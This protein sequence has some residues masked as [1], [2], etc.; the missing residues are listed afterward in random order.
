MG[1]DLETN[2]VKI[3]IPHT[4]YRI[5]SAESALGNMLFP[6][7]PRFREHC[8]ATNLDEIK[9][10]SDLP[11]GVRSSLDFLSSFVP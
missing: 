7:G 10:L 4:L 1:V 11:A 2:T 6:A 3:D 9:D 8:Q 5:Y